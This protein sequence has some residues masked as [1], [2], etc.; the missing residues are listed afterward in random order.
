[1]TNRTRPGT[2][3]E[4]RTVAWLVEVLGHA[5]GEAV[6]A[7]AAGDMTA[8]DRLRKAFAKQQRNLRAAARQRA[9]GAD[10]QY[11]RWFGDRPGGVRVP[12]ELALSPNARLAAELRKQARMIEQV[13]AEVQ[14]ATGQVPAYWRA[15]RI[16]KAL[17]DA[18]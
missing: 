2:D 3:S 13:A 11:R 12:A 7:V 6:R 5:P 4:L 10:A 15:V 1:M 9:I 17:R 18:E 16:L 8:S 14:P